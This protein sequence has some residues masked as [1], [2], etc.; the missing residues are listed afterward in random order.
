MSF[1]N[2][3]HG[4]RLKESKETPVLYRIK[5]GSVVVL[6]TAPDADADEFPLNVPVLLNGTPE[7]AAALNSAGTL[8]DAIDDVFDQGPVRV[9]AI[10]IQQGADA[11]ATLSNFVGDAA[12]LTG[13]HAMKKIEPLLHIKPRIVA[14]PGFTSGDGVTKNP[15]VAELEGVLEDLKAVAFV[16]GPD[17]TD[18]QAIAYRN[19]ISSQ[20]IMII[21]PK[22]LVW[23]TDTNANVARPASA[24][25]AGA[26]AMSDEERGFHWSVSSMPIKGITGVSRNVSYGSQAN[27]LNENAVSTIIPGHKGG[28]IVYGN[29]TP[30]AESLWAF[31]CVRRA[32][33]FTNELLLDTFREYVDRPFSAA[34][35]KLMIGSGNAVLRDL[36]N[37]GHLL[38]G[39]LWLDEKKNSPEKLVNGQILLSVKSEPPAPMED[40]GLIGHREIL[41]YLPVTKAALQA[42]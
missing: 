34:N 14:I 35:V 12:T 7:K 24:R 33:D 36:T 4:T 19:Q 38:G 42:A 27:H 37:Q 11:A 41:Y 8:K 15:V 2:F 5:S 29:R 16:D 1:L 10:R 30:S 22:V 32:A 17:T 3:H 6:G 18:D 31:L 39:E 25:V 40:I 20:R 26:Q 28:L 9:V 23:D 13:V 21:D